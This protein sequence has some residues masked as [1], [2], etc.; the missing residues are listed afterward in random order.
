MSPRE[1]EIKL[2]TRDSE[3]LTRLAERREL[4][5]FALAPPGIREQE[6]RYLDT[7]DFRLF[8]AGYSLRY[9]RRGGALVATLKEIPSVEG[10]DALR[11]REEIEAAVGEDGAL[12]GPLADLVASLTGGVDL[13][14]VLR[15]R[16]RRRV[17]DILAGGAKVAELCLDEV[18]V[19]RGDGSAPVDR[20][21]EIEVEES[22]ESSAVLS[23]IGEELLA[24]LE[25]SVLSKF[26]RGLAMLG[27]L[28]PARE[29]ARRRT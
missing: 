6:D 26:E 24:T 27:L 18:E 1:R 13:R 15:L 25:P 5:G 8:A 4:A 19:A 2:V 11:D 28:E 29:A 20:F 9:R 21:L 22:G 3:V 17:R 14:A 23:T 7:E 10:R 12:P 16:T